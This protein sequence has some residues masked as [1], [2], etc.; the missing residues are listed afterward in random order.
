[1]GE[2]ESP[3]VCVGGAGRPVKCG[4]WRHGGYLAAPV[5][6]RTIPWEMKGQRAAECRYAGGGRQPFGQ[7]ELAKKTVLRRKAYHAGKSVTSHCQL[8]ILL[9]TPRNAPCK[10]ILNA[11][12][13]LYK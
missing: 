13:L 9:K 3:G 6:G 8:V 2:P 4:S 7:E 11:F 12:M 5:A 1:M 10:A